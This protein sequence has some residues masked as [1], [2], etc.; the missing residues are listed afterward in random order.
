MSHPENLPQPQITNVVLSVF[1]LASVGLDF[2][3]NLNI[4]KYMFSVQLGPSW[5]TPFEHWILCD[6][7]ELPVT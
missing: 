6:H 5:E 2:E 1:E 3:Y 4:K 7:W